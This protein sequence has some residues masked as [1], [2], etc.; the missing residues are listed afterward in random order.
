MSAYPLFFLYKM[1]KAV[2][3]KILIKHF[4]FNLSQICPY[5]VHILTKKN[6]IKVG[7]T[8]IDRPRVDH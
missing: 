2:L 5:F 6:D 7:F 4:F 1:D 8:D 3:D